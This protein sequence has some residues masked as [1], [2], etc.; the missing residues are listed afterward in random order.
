MVTQKTFDVALEIAKDMDRRVGSNLDIA[1]KRF[2]RRHEA[3]YKARDVD[4]QDLK[5]AYLETALMLPEPIGTSLLALQPA[6]ASKPSHIAEWLW[7]A[8]VMRSDGEGLLDKAAIAAVTGSTDYQDLVRYIFDAFFWCLV[9]AEISPNDKDLRGSYSKLFAARYSAVAA[10]TESHPRN[11]VG[12]KSGQFAAIDRLIQEALGEF[13][14][15][16]EGA[17]GS[18]DFQDEQTP[19]EIADTSSV[20]EETDDGTGAEDLAEATRELCAKLEDLRM[21][22]NRLKT[23][24]TQRPKLRPITMAEPVANQ[25]RW[26][27]LTDSPEHMAELWWLLSQVPEDE[28]ETI[29]Y[30]VGVAISRGK[31]LPGIER[32]QEI[33]NEILR[34]QKR[35]IC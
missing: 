6:D 29:K 33:L 17:T 3:L 20:D 1:F 26:T 5:T 21:Q 27:E 8:T 13:I 28:R 11:P 25:D 4:D 34:K 24:L 32:F 16:S 18:G 19:D 10:L 12:T 31:R 23:T 9:I 22:V 14:R 7:K 2:M 35:L 30:A 15:L